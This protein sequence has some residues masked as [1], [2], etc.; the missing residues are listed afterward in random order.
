MSGNKTPVLPYR[1]WR[2]LGIIPSSADWQRARR[3]VKVL[4]RNTGA[5]LRERERYR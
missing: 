1:E 2:M 5:G 4:A 3:E